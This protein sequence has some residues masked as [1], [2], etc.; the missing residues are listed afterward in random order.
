MKSIRSLFLLPLL[1]LNLG[2]YAAEIRPLVFGIFPYVSQAQL[3]QVHAPLKT[4]L[5]QKLG[6]PIDMVTAPDFPEFLARTQRGEFDI[7]LT[8]PHFGRLAEVR[9]GYV[10][11]AKTGHEV[12]GIF[13]VA[14][15][16]D[17]KRIKDLKGKTV[18]IAQPIS[19]VYQLAEETLR[20]QGLIHGKTVTVLETRTHNNALAA[21]TRK[22]AD[23]AVTGQ[24][25]WA[26]AT[27]EVKAQLREIGATPAVPGFMLMAHKRLPSKQISQIKQI[28]LGFDK[29]PE[30]KAYFDKTFILRFEPINSKVMRSLD[31]Y[32]K[33]LTQTATAAK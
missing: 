18:M 32:T 22:E 15:D 7:I 16:S 2:A 14:A 6:Q 24:G 12:Q 33:I 17:I 19:V 10:R 27:P 13:L 31:P 29:T 25:L 26:Q 9:D 20:K 30:G 4:Q 5:E 28:L 8:A 11:L 3:M 1:L 21:P 23:A